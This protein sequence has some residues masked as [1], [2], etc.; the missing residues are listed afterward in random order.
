M[1]IAVQAKFFKNVGPQITYLIDSKHSEK[2][3]IQSTLYTLIIRGGVQTKT[4]WLSNSNTVTV[5][6]C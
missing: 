4:A 1:S 3:H 5:T 6:K 2:L